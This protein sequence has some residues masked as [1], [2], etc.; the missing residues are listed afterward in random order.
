[1]L[2]ASSERFHRITS[3]RDM[4]QTTFAPIYSPSPESDLAQ[5]ARVGRR[6]LAVAKNIQNTLPHVLWVLAGVNAR[7]DTLRLVV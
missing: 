3:A 1:M 4:H 5:D 6:R 7:P 2:M